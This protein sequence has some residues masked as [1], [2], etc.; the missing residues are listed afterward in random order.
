MPLLSLSSTPHRTVVRPPARA[1]VTRAVPEIET[2]ERFGVPFACFSRRGEALIV[3]AEADRL[4]GEGDG[5]LQLTGE[6][7]A[8]VRAADRSGRL[9]ATARGGPTFEALPVPAL[10]SRAA[11]RIGW[12]T[13]GANVLVAIVLILASSGPSDTAPSFEGRLSL[14]E[15]EVAGLIA[16]GASTKAI[17]AALGISPHTARRHTERVFEKCGVRCRAALAAMVSRQLVG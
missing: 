14:R 4:L 3:S 15:R 2:L 6:L 13:V 10:G 9:M 7:E 11:C 17:A 12:V 5:S 8:A 16:R 1:E